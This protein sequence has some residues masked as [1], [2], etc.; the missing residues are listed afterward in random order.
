MRLYGLNSGMLRRGLVV[1]AICSLTLA[2]SIKAGFALFD[3]TQGYLEQQLHNVVRPLNVL[4]P[5]ALTVDVNRSAKGDRSGTSALARNQRHK[6]LEQNVR[7]WIEKN[8]KW[9]HTYNVG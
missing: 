3:A 8:G 2:G 4:K 1:L 7:F 5:Q 9:N 6:D